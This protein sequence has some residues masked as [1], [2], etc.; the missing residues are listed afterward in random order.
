MKKIMYITSFVIIMLVSFLGIT[1]S[2][3]YNGMDSLKF[4]LI[5]PTTL[6]MDVNTDYQEYGIKVF[7]NGVDVSSSVKIDSS[8]VNVNMLGEYKVKYEIDVDGNKEY[9][10]RDVIVIDNISP[11]IKLK[12]NEIIYINLNDEYYEE[13]Y[14]VSDNYDVGL[15][16]KVSIRGRVNT[17]VVGEYELLYSTID[18]SGNIGSVKRLVIVRELDSNEG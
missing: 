4:I 5:G 11:E 12:G 16:K 14:E 17:S 6:Y 13:G 18:S 10:Y 3:E 2:Y 15:E 1:Y 7:N 9:V 8:L